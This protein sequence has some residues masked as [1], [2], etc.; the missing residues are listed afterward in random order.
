MYI[1]MYMQLL[2]SYSTYAYYRMYCITLH[3]VCA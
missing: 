1:I 2:L 3:C